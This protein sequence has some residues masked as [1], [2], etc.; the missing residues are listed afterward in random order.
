MFSGS[1]IPIQ[2]L[3]DY[4]ESGDTI[5]E[6]LDDFPSVTKHQLVQVLEIAR[7][8]S[9]RHELSRDGRS[10]YDILVRGPGQGKHIK[11]PITVRQKNG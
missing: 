9:S 3:F 6:I 4:S 8:K 5:E 10:V 2:T 11:N 1:R 7:N